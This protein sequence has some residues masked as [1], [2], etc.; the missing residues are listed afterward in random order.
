MNEQNKIHTHERT[1]FYFNS[2]KSR[3]LI[4]LQLECSVFFNFIQWFLKLNFLFCNTC[5]YFY[6]ILVWLWLW[7]PFLMLFFDAVTV[8]HCYS[9]M[10]DTFQCQLTTT[11]AGRFTFIVKPFSLKNTMPHPIRGEKCICFNRLLKKK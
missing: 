5:Y 1:Q 8:L 2:F 10:N 6:F 9:R 11:H 7:R 3:L 4:K